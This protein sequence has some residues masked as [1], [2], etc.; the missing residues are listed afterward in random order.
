MISSEWYNLPG[1]LDVENNPLFIEKACFDS[2]FK[3]C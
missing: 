3:V 1:A 2:D